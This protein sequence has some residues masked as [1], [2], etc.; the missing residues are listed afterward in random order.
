MATRLTFDRALL[1]GLLVLASLAALLTTSCAAPAETDSRLGAAV[2][3]LP[4][5]GFVKAVGGDM[6]DVTVMVPPGADPHTYELA[7][8][9]MTKLAHAE[10]YFKVGSGVEFELV[11]LD[12]ILAQNR[13]LQVV[14]CSAGIQLREQS[15]EG[16]APGMPDPHVWMSPANAMIMVRNICD[17]LVQADPGN[18]SFY[19]T[20]RD[21]YL[22][23][24]EEL[25][26]D[27]AT[28]V[29]GMA[30]RVIMVYHD[31]LGYFADEYGLTVLTIEAEGKEPTA[32]DL[33]RL[34][35]QA[36][37]YGIKVI[38]ASPE[39]SQAAPKVIAGEIGGTVV[40]VDPL[41]E[42]YI[43]NMRAFLHELEAATQ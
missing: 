19:E 23:Q 3:I 29:S 37:E 35:D 7:P 27:I 42:D 28:A 41:A 38:F 21:A 9:Q 15:A 24:L 30:N 16:E 5:A 17:G 22:Q 33:A 13:Q 34:I 18:Q 40:L 4:Q 8:S 31:A 2:T 25:D 6:V 26:R 11:W 43:A 1:A 14:D 32:A 20:N 36:R 39:F 10:L 12:K